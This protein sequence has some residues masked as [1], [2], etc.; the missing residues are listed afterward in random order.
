MKYIIALCVASVLCLVASAQQQ[1]PDECELCGM[2]NDMQAQLDDMQDALDNGGR[3]K[4]K[5]G[6]KC[7]YIVIYMYLL[8]G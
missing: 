8:H 7:L 3:A 1:C 4:S 6:N 5:R 2:V